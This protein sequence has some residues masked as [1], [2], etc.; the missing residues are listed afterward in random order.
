MWRRFT[1]RMCTEERSDYNIGAAAQL[2]GSASG[3]AS[4]WLVTRIRSLIRGVLA[5]AGEPP[6]PS[7]VSRVTTAETE[8][9]RPCFICR[10]RWARSLT[11][12]EGGNFAP[13]ALCGAREVSPDSTADSSRPNRALIKLERWPRLPIPAR[14]CAG[15]G[16]TKRLV[17]G[18]VSRSSGVAARLDSMSS[19]RHSLAAC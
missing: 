17:D 2:P 19:L 6:S 16:T 5:C 9:P 7:P 13:L 14:S 8:L 15:S 18:S 11:D 10:R 1:L 12:G 3:S 4:G